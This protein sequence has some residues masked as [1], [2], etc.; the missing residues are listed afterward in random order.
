MASLEEIALK[1]SAEAV[2]SV[3]RVPWAMLLTM[4]MIERKKRSERVRLQLGED[5][6]SLAETS[7]DCIVS[8][9][10]AGAVQFATPAI[11]RMFGFTND[12]QLPLVLNYEIDAWG[13]V[14]RTIE[15]ARATEQAR[16]TTCVWFASR[17]KLT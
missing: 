3:R 1:R 11:T 10:H 16:R 7:P 14:R 8:V 12:Y 17:S 4:E 6:R 15:A 9:D 2:R 5:I 13:R